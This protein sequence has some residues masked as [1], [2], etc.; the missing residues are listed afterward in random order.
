MASDKKIVATDGREKIAGS[1]YVEIRD[2][3]TANSDMKFKDIIGDIAGISPGSYYN[4]TSENS[5]KYGRISLFTVKNISEFFNLP[6][7]IFDCSE[8]FT[9][10]VKEKIAQVIKNK[11]SIS[12][13][14]RS[15]SK[16]ISDELVSK[17][18]Y[19]CKME[20]KSHQDLLNS[21]LEESFLVPFMNRDHLVNYFYLIEKYKDSMNRRNDKNK[22]GNLKN[23]IKL[24]EIGLFYCIAYE[25]LIMEYI[26]DNEFLVFQDEIEI[27]WPNEIWNF[28][29]RVT[30]P[31]FAEIALDLFSNYCVE[32]VSQYDCL[33]SLSDF[34]EDLRLEEIKVLSN[35]ISI[36][37]GMLKIKNIE[38]YKQL[39]GIRQED[40]IDFPLQKYIVDDFINS[41]VFEKY[42][43]N[44][45]KILHLLF[46]KIKDIG[47]Q[48]Y[49]QLKV[50]NTFTIYARENVGNRL[51]VVSVY[52]DSI[53]FTIMYSDI[54][55]YIED[56]EQN[57]DYI[58]TELKEKY[59]N[60]PEY[61]E[62]QFSMN[63][64]CFIED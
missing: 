27:D 20:D 16:I 53:R 45:K 13:I 46:Q 39:I 19:A 61:K 33:G 3:I 55:S 47:I 28:E 1:R 2:I 11:Y 51:A 49:I 56:D 58:I 32:D 57:N 63:K 30:Y 9:D 25:D 40:I 17:L 6:I 31:S 12:N 18:E 8:D 15:S 54:S 35:A 23:K 52:D 10:E 21:V 64:K 59:D 37:R 43:S 42:C 7:G 50:D 62:M 44:S 38:W 34:Y 60:P 4:Y 14:S 22:R 26:R 5:P 48:I 24:R 41:D 29:F 36:S